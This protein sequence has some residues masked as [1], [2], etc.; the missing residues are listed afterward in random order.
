MGR[1]AAVRALRTTAHTTQQQLRGRDR[2][3]RGDHG[4]RGRCRWRG[5]PRRRAARS[6][7][8]LR[9]RLGV[10]K[11]AVLMVCGSRSFW[12]RLMY[13]TS[14]NSKSSK[15]SIAPTLDTHTRFLGQSL[16]GLRG[17]RGSFKVREKSKS[18]FSVTISFF[19]MQILE[20]RVE[21]PAPRSFRS[22]V[23]SVAT[24]AE[25]PQRRKEMRPPSSAAH[26]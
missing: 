2:G 23:S 18:K 4:Q 6:R 12:P 24:A 3:I 7:G 26:K 1:L 20:L 25:S 15:L 14:I 13:H 11:V 21:F 17:L 16:R 22:M 9:G 8:R 5:A 10:I 19:H